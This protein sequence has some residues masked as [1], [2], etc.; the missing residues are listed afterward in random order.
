[1]EEPVGVVDGRASQRLLAGEQA[2]A[3]AAVDDADR[4]LHR[5][6]GVDGVGDDTRA[7]A[8]L[9][10]SSVREARTA[11]DAALGDVRDALAIA[12]A[13]GDR[14]LE[15][16]ALRA[17]GGDSA[18]AMRLPA[19]EVAAPLEAGLRLAADLGDRRAEA[20]FST[21]LTVVD[22]SRLRLTQGLARAEAAVARARATGSVEAVMLALDGLKTVLSYL[23]AVDR[24]EAVLAEL[25][26]LVRAR[27]NTWLL[28]WVVMESAFVPAGRGDL[29]GAR[30]RMAQA[31][32]LNAQSG[33]GAYAGY[34][35]AH[36]GWFARLAGDPQQACLLGRRALAA[37]SREHPWWFATAAGM[38]A[39]T[40]VEL[41]SPADHDEARDVARRGLEVADDAAMIR[42]LGASVLPLVISAD[43]GGEFGWVQLRYSLCPA[44][45]R[46]S[47]LVTRV[48]PE[49]RLSPHVPM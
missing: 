8:L 49:F 16:S 12:R 33:F 13:T 17:L 41:G 48:E 35:M 38:L 37:T 20:D 34:L 10:R 44:R 18:V 21:R 5:V 11:Y 45:R 24:L 42:P 19:P 6:L 32:Q 31:Q 28:Q 36:D 15:M 39:A 1:M 4:L 7:R 25:E 29:A 2:L 26:P 14:R 3:R 23:G 47:K 40:L 46:C 30:A 22:A 43:T 27:H 9:A